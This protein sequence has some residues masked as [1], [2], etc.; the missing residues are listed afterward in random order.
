MRIF[1]LEVIPALFKGME[2]IFSLKL[3]SIEGS[4][5][6]PLPT[7]MGVIIL[8]GIKRLNVLSKNLQEDTGGGRGSCPLAP[9]FIYSREIRQNGQT[10]LNAMPPS[11]WPPQILP[12]VL[13]APSCFGEAQERPGHGT[14]QVLF[15]W[16]A[17]WGG[18]M[19]LV[20]IYQGEE[21][22]KSLQA[23]GKLL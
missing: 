4:Q 10:L 8:P 2:Q 7:D 23:H 6:L 15:S 1:S 11:F 12:G 14:A 22:P 3:L 20:G 21:T 17:V 16:E 9:M 13:S 18:R 5:L 19:S